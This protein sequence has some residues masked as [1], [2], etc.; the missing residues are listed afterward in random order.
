[1]SRGETDVAAALSGNSLRHLEGVRVERTAST[2][3]QRVS[4]NMHRM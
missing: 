1:M 2:L 4:I 3:M